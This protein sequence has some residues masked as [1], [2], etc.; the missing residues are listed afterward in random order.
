MTHQLL[1]RIWDSKII[2]LKSDDR[3]AKAREAVLHFPE[4]VPVFEQD[5]DTSFIILSCF[6][7]TIYIFKPTKSHK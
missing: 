4:K 5:S 6:Q 1:F 2:Q 3:V 7:I